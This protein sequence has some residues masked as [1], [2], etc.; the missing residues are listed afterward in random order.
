MITVQ[1]YIFISLIISF[2]TYSLQAMQIRGIAYPDKTSSKIY[3]KWFPKK[4]ANQYKIYV[5][6]NKKIT[7]IKTLYSISDVAT[8][9]MILGK[10]YQA[11]KKEASGQSHNNKII[12]DLEFCQKSIHSP[13][14]IFSVLS[15]YDKRLSQILAT[16]TTIHITKPEHKNNSR[17]YIIRSYWNN[18]LVEQAKTNIIHLQTYIRIPQPTH[19]KHHNYAHHT[20][21][22]WKIHHN[23][24]VIGYNVYLSDDNKIFKKHNK[25]LVTAFQTQSLNKK[26]I[27]HKTTG[28]GYL[29]YKLMDL[30]THQTY[31]V[32]ITS[33]FWHHQESAFSEIMEFQVL[34]VREVI[35]PIITKIEQAQNSQQAIVHWQIKKHQPHI[36][37]LNIY[38]ASNLQGKYRKI[39]TIPINPL[40]MSYKDPSILKSNQTYWYQIRAVVK[41]SKELPTQLSKKFHIP[42]SIKPPRIHIIKIQA[43]P[44]AIQITASATT[45][46][47]KVRYEIFRSIG[48]QKNFEKIAEMNKSRR[49]MDTKL[50]HHYIYCYRIQAL[51]PSGQVSQPSPS[52]C[53]QPINGDNPPRPIQFYLSQE[54]NGVY[55]EWKIMMNYHAHT[56]EIYRNNIKSKTVTQK[57]ASHSSYYKLI[58]LSGTE[59]HYVDHTAIPGETYTYFVLAKTRN[60][61]TSKPSTHLSIQF[62]YH[63]SVLPIE[64]IRVYKQSPRSCRVLFSYNDYIKGRFI[65]TLLDNTTHHVLKKYIIPI[66]RNTD[67]QQE[68]NKFQV[69]TYTIKIQVQNDNRVTSP[70]VTFNTLSIR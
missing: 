50:N 38:R 51:Q 21:I 16:H 45:S 61:L 44:N 19:I 60:N 66:Q 62:K 57:R 47:H 39:N 14:A 17:R 59:R 26:R 37:Y 55:M 65:I 49:Y 36:Q 46:N 3:L 18:K 1:W 10:D 11:Y 52:K 48:H 40:L 64:N 63:Q 30:S 22:Q 29:H 2:S 9:Q 56:F 32:K 70:S 27:P 35:S 28:K 67:I 13:D 20:E 68:L 23:T 41:P 25:Q 4:L 8:I 33:V 24:G 34:P 7:L 58:S 43:F 15:I 5:L 31:F 42:K 12:S 69:G 53:T 6:E 54:P